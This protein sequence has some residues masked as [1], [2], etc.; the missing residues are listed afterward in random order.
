M[1]KIKHI[2]FPG[3]E[4]RSLKLL[5]GRRACKLRNLG[6]L[7]NHSPES[8]GPPRQCQGGNLPAEANL[9]RERAKRGHLEHS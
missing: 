6:D 2:A 3:R 9:E 7:K 8:S 5:A 1:S 4:V